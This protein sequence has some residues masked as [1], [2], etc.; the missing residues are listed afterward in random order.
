VSDVHPQV[1]IGGMSELD[2]EIVVHRL[3]RQLNDKASIGKP[4]VAY[5]E[6]LTRP[7]DGEM[8]ATGICS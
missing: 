3:T 2:L 4:Q 7:T 6:A 5:K 8:K 1:I